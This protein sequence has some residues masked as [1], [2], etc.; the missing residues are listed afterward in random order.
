MSIFAGTKEIKAIKVGGTNV[1]A[2]YAGNEKVW[3][4]L[5]EI[6]T[7]PNH[8]WAGRVIYSYGTPQTDGGRTYTE[9]GGP[10]SGCN[11]TKGDI[12]LMVAAH[13]GGA[14]PY[15]N[16]F[17]FGYTGGKHRFRGA[18]TSF[19][20]YFKLNVGLCIAPSNGN[21]LNHYITDNSTNTYYP[22][23]FLAYAWT[24]PKELFGN[25]SEDDF[26]FQEA[27][28][29]RPINIT[30]GQPNS[31]ALEVCGAM[32]SSTGTDIRNLTHKQKGR[33]NGNAYTLAGGYKYIR[34]D[35]RGR[36]SESTDDNA[37]NTGTA[38][39]MYIY[40]KR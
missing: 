20:D 22:Y 16:T 37:V 30:D 24:F 11:V 15:Q 14:D 9:R 12:H 32:G 26:Q 40:L 25:P 4:S 35:D 23:D 2:V 7:A 13:M 21:A 19:R 34:L 38:E 10:I 6:P 39:R 36:Y 3:P 17:D 28:F 8:T 29:N 33:S 5:P 18:T 31:I 1:K 27:S